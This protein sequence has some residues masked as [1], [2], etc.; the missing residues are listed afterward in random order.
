MCYYDLFPK[1]KEK[2]R[3]WLEVAMAGQVKVYERGCKTTGIEDLPK[4][5]RLVIEHKGYYL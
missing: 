1:Y 2:I 5:V 4:W 3:G